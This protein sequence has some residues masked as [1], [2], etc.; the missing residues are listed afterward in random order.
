MFTIVNQNE[1]IKQAIESDKSNAL[2]LEKQLIS[3]I[4]IIFL[5]P[6]YFC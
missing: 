6:N 1:T 2:L 4:Y 5:T 3:N